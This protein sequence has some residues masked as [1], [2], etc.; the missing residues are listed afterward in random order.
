MAVWGD[1]FQAREVEGGAVGLADWKGRVSDSALFGSLRVHKAE[2]GDPAPAPT[3]S[4]TFLV[5]HSLRES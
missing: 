4:L 1:F 5:A 2:R 3:D